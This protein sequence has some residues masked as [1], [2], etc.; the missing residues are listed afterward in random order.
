M[1]FH[2]RHGYM[3]AA[4]LPLSD[5]VICVDVA[6]FYRFCFLLLLISGKRGATVTKLTWC[7]YGNPQACYMNGVL[8]WSSVFRFR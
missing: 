3:S 4:Y 6:V 1:D 7:G 5:Q 2:P 8:V